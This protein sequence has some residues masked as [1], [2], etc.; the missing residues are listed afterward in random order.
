M[1]VP[2]QLRGP[3][4]T[5]LPFALLAV[6][7]GFTLVTGGARWPELVLCGLA[8]GWMLGLF[9]LPPAWRESVPVMAVFL[10][11]LTAITLVL[12]L[13][14]P[15]FG[16]FTPAL[17]VY[18]FRLLP[19]PWVLPGVAAVAAV[20]GTA[21]AYGVD[22]STFAGVLAYLAVLAVNAGPMCG[23]AWF[24]WRSGERNREREKAL[25][26]LA[27]ANRRLEASLAENA[28]LHDR[29]L[30]S[31]RDTAVHD[32]RE[33]MA[34]EIH[35]TLA[36][37]LTGIITQ[38]Q[39]AEHDPDSWR[40]RTTAATALARESLTEARRSVHALRPEPLRASRLSEALE[41]VADRWSALHGVAVQVTTTGAAVPLSPETEIALLR[42][43][44]EAL[45]NVA[46]H[47]RATRAGVTLSYLDGEVALDVRDD[48]RGF[49]P[50]DP[51]GD[52]TGGG[53]GLT[54]MRQRIESLSGTLR[55]ESEPGGGTGIS[56]RVP[57]G[58]RPA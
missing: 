23:F 36:Q 28:A 18:A 54:A 27:E 35:D 39:A 22:K 47:A 33:R 31:A 34:R 3:V 26:E 57:P 55:I 21:Q 29:L 8:A 24:A 7:T 25:R 10:G 16:C 48:G 13:D 1:R 15:W 43:A 52:T 40:R 56:A 6:L 19:W 5:S 37:G 41:G 51:R 45:A 38:L 11:V 50:L 46:G 44:Q 17:Y 14:A 53:F 4:V 32:E 2:E 20:A 30:A 49:D 9:A 12:V 42:T 58:A